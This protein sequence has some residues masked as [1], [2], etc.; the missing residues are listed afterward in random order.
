[1]RYGTRSNGN[2]HGLVL[3]KPF[4]VCKMLDFIGYDER[5]DLSNTRVLEP[6]AGEGAFA[7]EI[8]SRLYKSSRK[9]GFDFSH[10]LKNICLFEIDEVFSRRLLERI[11]SE[12]INLSI[13]NSLP[14]IYIQDYLISEVGTFDLVIGNPP[15]VRHENIPE[16]KKELYRSI[17]GAFSHRSDL[18]IAFYEKALTSLN[19]GGKLSFICSN[20]WLKNQ[21]GKRLRE[22][23]KN[24]FSL[25]EVIDLEETNPF[26]E[27]VMAYPAITNIK[28]AI[29]SGKAEYYKSHDLS[30]LNRF[31]TKFKPL[32][33][34]KTN[35]GNWFSLELKKGATL[36]NLDSIQNQGFNIGIGVATGCDSVFIRKDFKELVEKEVLLPILISKDLKADQFNW[37]GH[38]IL[39]P[40][41]EWGRLIN[42]NR[43]PKTKNYLEKH[44]STLESRYISR[45][46][47]SFWFRTIDKIN[48]YFTYKPKILLPDISRNQYIFIDKGKYYPHH[49][50]YYISHDEISKLNLLAG[51]LMSNFVRNQLEEL[52]NKMNGGYPRWQ[53]QNLKKLRIPIID[54]MPDSV[55]FELEQ[56][57]LEKD[58][59]K[60]NELIDPKNFSKYKIKVRQTRL[61]EPDNQQHPQKKLRLFSEE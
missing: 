57:Y 32:R 35:S 11:K 8:I 19:P 23:I 59:D 17:F 34:L 2:Q 42:L 24:R 4:I 58:I 48:Y 14:Q 41:D 6:A 15:Y 31:K 43:F 50:L 10:A 61:F 53:S 25:L 20:R 5:F 47:C 60:V 13:K 30:D 36:S 9:F 26:E 40:Y 55:K 12:L 29:N 1:M 52:G 45:R 46:N 22:L 16:D 37:G 7:I 39:N 28:N 49:N 54:A 27:E 33:R 56:A 51:I 18:Y 3:T 21:Y 44:R 38:F